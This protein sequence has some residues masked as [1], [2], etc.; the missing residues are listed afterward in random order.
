[1]R[2]D[3]GAAD[4]LDVADGALA[5]TLQVR[6]A[7]LAARVQFVQTAFA[8]GN[9]ARQLRRTIPGLLLL[10][11][12][13]EGQVL[14]VDQLVEADIDVSADRVGL[15]AA[16]VGNLT[17]KR[18]EAFAPQGVCSRCSCSAGRRR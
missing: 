5:F 2:Q 3:P 11:Q 6:Q 18:V 9:V 13:G 4:A 1:M 8:L 12:T 16:L 10:D 15:M 7:S 14:A 17:E